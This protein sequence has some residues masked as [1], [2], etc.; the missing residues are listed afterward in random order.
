LLAGIPKAPSEYSPTANPTRAK[1]RRDL[2]LDLL[3]KP[4]FDSN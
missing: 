4:G 1:E 3:A 2:I